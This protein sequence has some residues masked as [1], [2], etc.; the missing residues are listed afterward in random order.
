MPSMTRTQYSIRIH[1][2]SNTLARF[3]SAIAVRTSDYASY[4]LAINFRTPLTSMQILLSV[5]LTPPMLANISIEPAG[6]RW[7]DIPAGKKIFF[8]RD[9]TGAGGVWQR[10]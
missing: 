8:M 7:T 1:F 2:L 9:Q 5:S 10:E 6:S 3:G 4:L